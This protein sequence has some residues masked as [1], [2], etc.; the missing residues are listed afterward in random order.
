MFFFQKNV[1]LAKMFMFFAKCLDR[2]AAVWNHMETLSYVGTHARM[3]ETAPHLCRNYDMP[4]AET[5]NLAFC[6]A[7]CKKLWSQENTA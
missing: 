1:F 5:K 7:M 3:P 6:P 4:S 2:A